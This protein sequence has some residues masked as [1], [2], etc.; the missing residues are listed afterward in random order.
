M[1][2]LMWL[3]SSRIRAQDPA[4]ASQAVL[5]SQLEL[6]LHGDLTALRP[7]IREL[8]EQTTANETQQ[9]SLS[10]LLA[11]SYQDEYRKDQSDATLRSAIKA[12]ERY[13]ERF[14][15]GARAGFVHFNLG[16]AYN[17]LKQYEPAMSSFEWLFRHSNNAT[18]RMAARDKMCG[19]YIKANKAAEGIPLFQEVFQT[20]Q[21]DPEL[22]ARS[23]SWLIQGYLAL[24]SAK[25]ASPYLRYL[26]GSYEAIY[27][28]GFNIRL[29][30]AGD[31]LFERQDY[32]EAILLY[33]F[34]KPRGSIIDFYRDLISQ[35]SKRIRT[36]AVG[37]DPYL[38]LEGQLKSA[39]SKLKAVR[40][41]RSYDVD[42]KW[43]IARVFRQTQR[44]WEALW[45]FYHLYQDYPEHEQAEDFLFIAFK[46]AGRLADRSM[47][48]GLADEYLANAGDRNYEAEVILDLAAFYAAED[49]HAELRALCKDYIETS[50]NHRVAAQLLNY[51]GNH[52]LQVAQFSELNTYLQPLIKH[53]RAEEPLYET[54]R[55][56]T[57]LSELLLADYGK[58]AVTLKTFLQDY[59]ERSPY[60]EDVF[61]RYGICLYGLEQHQDAE[62]QFTQLRRPLSREYPARR[63][64]ALPGRLE[65]C[66]P[67]LPRIC[68]A[69][70][71][72]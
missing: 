55:Y 16:G 15:S 33:S 70:P 45:A 1:L 50:R 9:E 57:G 68:Q 8:L 11:L 52:Y 13:L 38:V 61:Y 31:A 54:I 58:A 19:I 7:V 72:G 26:T 3:P 69:L 71:C 44:N 14:P 5:F 43:R 60:H 41:I 46:Q 2:A 27:D 20:S 36:I 24:G 39:Q 35:L 67:R 6:G 4:N 12:Y 51:L 42:M 47:L 29:L 65:A 32:G 34:V 64:R 49:H 17:D 63:S 10:F 62:D 23:A 56:W 59:H 22:R 18:L 28:P 30:K 53:Y 25:Q 66:T 37:S 21:L 48:E 40:A